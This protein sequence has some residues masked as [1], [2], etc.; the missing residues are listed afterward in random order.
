MWVN[1]VDPDAVGEL[2]RRDT[3]LAELG[4]HHL[5]III[6]IDNNDRYRVSRRISRRTSMRLHSFTLWFAIPVMWLLPSA[7]AISATAVMNASVIGSMSM[8]IA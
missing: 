3:E 8:S 6:N 7:T 5:I 1:P 2:A 4:H